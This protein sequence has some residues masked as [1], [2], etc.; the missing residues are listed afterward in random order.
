MYKTAIADASVAVKKPATIPP[1]TIK[2]KNKL[3]TAPIKLE[4]IS[5]KLLFLESYMPIL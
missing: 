5:F 1:I 2:S 4:T 3:G